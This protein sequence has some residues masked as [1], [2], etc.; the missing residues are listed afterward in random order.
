M[1]LMSK[2][3]LEIKPG[4][5]ENNGQVSP[6]QQIEGLTKNLI[7]GGGQRIFVIVQNFIMA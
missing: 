2:N 1:G 4:V 6:R 7:S 3:F 5:T